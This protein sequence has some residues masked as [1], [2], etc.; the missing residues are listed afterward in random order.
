MTSVPYL[1]GGG[2]RSTERDAIKLDQILSTQIR[3][4]IPANLLEVR[5]IR[6]ILIKRITVNPTN[7]WKTNG[8]VFE[9]NEAALHKKKG[10]G[11]YQ[12]GQNNMT[13]K[14]ISDTPTN[15]ADN[16]APE[17]AE[18][19]LRKGKSSYD[20]NKKFSVE[21]QS[22]SRHNQQNLAKDDNFLLDGESI[23]KTT[24][25]QPMEIRR[26][27]EFQKLNEDTFF[28]CFYTINS[29]LNIEDPYFVSR[30][31]PS[32]VEL[33]DELEIHVFSKSA[34]I[35]LFVKGEV[36]GWKLSRQYHIKLSLLVNLGDDLDLIDSKLKHLK[37]VLLLKAADDCY[38]TLP[39]DAISPDIIKS[40]KMTQIEKTFSKLEDFHYKPTS[41]TY[42]Q[43]MTMNNYSR[44]IHDLLFTKLALENRISNELKND[45]SLHEILDAQNTLQNS[46]EHLAEV[47][48]KKISHNFQLEKKVEHLVK[49]KKKLHSRVLQ[50]KYP[51]DVKASET[52]VGLAIEA[53]TVQSENMKLNS[54]INFEKARIA[55][56]I[57]FIFPMKPIP[58]KH[59][60]SLFQT[61]FPAS[62]IPHTKSVEQSEHS[63]IIPISIISSTIIQRLSQISRPHSERLNSLIGYIAL[64]VLTTADIFNI[65][66]R[67]PIRELGSSSYIHDP[68]SNFNTSPNSNFAKVLNDPSVAKSSTI[69]P[70]FICRNATL[71]VKFTY[72]LLLLR[73]DLEQ[74]YEAE[75]IVKVEEFNLLVACK[76]W[77]TC[78]E[79]YIDNI[80]DYGGE[81]DDT[82]MGS[83]PDETIGEATETEE[84]NDFK[85]DDKSFTAQDYELPQND[86][87]PFSRVEP[88]RR[89]SGGSKFSKFSNV[90]VNSGSSKDLAVSGISTVSVE[91]NASLLVSE[92]NQKLHTAERI[93]HI[94]KHLLKGSSGKI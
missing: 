36:D 74:L 18:K 62:L 44:C 67:Y 64:I 91:S 20:L 5:H 38:Y 16:I 72:A 86:G 69:Y 17:I 76:I 58:Q 19:R 31:F 47:F 94:K 34:T 70:L 6:S 52:S 45:S 92:Y 3:S 56:V 84:F 55:S 27:L 49:R 30:V 1:E 33:A 8:D 14:N 80:V 39:N 28:D 83:F 48:Q 25:F 43:I 26:Q 32:H 85:G 51:A 66:L 60:F 59:D 93:K 81:L 54:Q 46:N 63:T 41:C 2:L 37:N 12:Q 71:A 4:S 40:L 90:S 65:P 35:N 50:L 9:S 61:C 87:K 77:L 22:N 23:R 29:F 57:Q 15:S 89:I 88:R 10:N 75:G 78:V 42:N 11:R 68:I 24:F 13:I 7:S 53:S 21:K 73:K 82:S 79:G